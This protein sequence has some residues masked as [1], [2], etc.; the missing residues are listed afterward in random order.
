MLHLNE[1]LTSRI[2]DY[3]INTRSLP[4]DIIRVRSL[5]KSHY[6]SLIKP[7]NNEIDSLNIVCAESLFLL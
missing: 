4:V 7:T 1:H 6:Y 2:H 3:Y 5:S